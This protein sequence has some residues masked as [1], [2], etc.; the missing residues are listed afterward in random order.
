M[1]E[2]EKPEKA[3][4]M[5][6]YL[7]EQ[8]STGK[9]SAGTKIP[10]IRD[11]QERFNISYS[12]AKRG[13]DYLC[14]IGLVE[15][16]PR[17]GIYVKEFSLNESTTKNLKIALFLDGNQV[18]SHQ[19]VYSTVFFGIQLYAEK[20]AN[21]LLVNYQQIKNAD[22][23]VVNQ[24]C[25]DVDG[26]IFLA[27]YDDSLKDFDF[28]IPAVGVCMDKSENGKLSVIDTFQTTE[29]AVEYFLKQGI[30][31]IEQFYED[32]T[33]ASY[34]KRN[35]LFAELW[36]EKGNTVKLLH[37]DEFELKKDT[38]YFFPTGTLLQ[39]VSEK[40]QEETGNKL[41]EQAVTLA[42]DGKC[43]LE[44]AYHKAPTI[45]LDWKLVGK[46]A[47]EECIY[48]INNQGSLP[49]RIYLPGILNENP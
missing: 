9:Y 10:P 44:P 3:R 46:Y 22:F 32:N 49:R 29:L 23:K 45:A 27:E 31:N 37:K 38:G 40:F 42:I 36:K 26:V 17:S 13:I 18:H 39:M 25:H 15:K 6:N 12:S 5:I 28:D 20:H 41:P 33:P 47:M 19:G 34:N 43:L 8:I 11:L 16:R 4:L 2:R 48:R 35:R 30:K 21:S 14:S 24:I 1:R 7:R